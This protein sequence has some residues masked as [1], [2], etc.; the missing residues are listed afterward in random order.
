MLQCASEL[1]KS[2]HGSARVIQSFSGRSIKDYG[3]AILDVAAA[4]NRRR[5]FF[6]ARTNVYGLWSSSSVIETV[7]VSA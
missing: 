5:N 3:T 4:S 7:I 1:E 2:T 6:E